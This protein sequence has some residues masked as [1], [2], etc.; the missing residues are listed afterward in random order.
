MAFVSKELADKLAAQTDELIEM[1]KN[2]IQRLD[3]LKAENEILKNEN[4]EL[5]EAIKVLAKKKTA[6]CETR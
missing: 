4:M 1:M 6:K 5:K 3:A 2:S